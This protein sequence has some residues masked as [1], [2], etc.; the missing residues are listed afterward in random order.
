LLNIEFGAGSHSL[1][2]GF[3]ATGQTTN[4]FWNLFRLYDPNTRPAM[5]LVF[6][7][8]LPALKLADGTA[9]DVFH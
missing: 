1:K 8:R 3:A 4:D 6:N 2:T 7:G 5:A 9:T